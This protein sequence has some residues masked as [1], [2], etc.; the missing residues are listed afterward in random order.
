MSE[1]TFK[2]KREEIIKTLSEVNVSQYVEKKMG[3]N[4]LSWANAWAVLIQ[5]Y[6]TATYEFAEYPE[7]IQDVNTK[8]W[9]PTNRTVDYRQT[10]AG[11]EVTAT[12]NIEGELFSMSLYVMDN[13]NKVVPN[14]NYAQINKTQQRCL[15]KALALAGL[16]LNLYQGEDLPTGENMKRK[17]I[18]PEQQAM[19]QKANKLKKEIGQLLKEVSSAT[20]QNAKDVENIVYETIRNEYQGASEMKLDEKLETMVKVLENMKKEATGKNSE[21]MTLEEVEM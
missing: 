10:Q 9:I 11:C 18:N 1:A 7:Y 4:Y 5:Y 13:R 16:G 12:V 3:L 21:E 8:Q 19:Q 20:K 6:P 15:V 14:P 2:N 17:G